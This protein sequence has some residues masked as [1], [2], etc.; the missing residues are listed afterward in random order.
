MIRAN[1]ITLTEEQKKSLRERFPQAWPMD[2]RES[3]VCICSTSYRDNAGHSRVSVGGRVGMLHRNIYAAVVGPIPEDSLVLHRCGNAW[4]IN[5]CHLYLGD[6][7]Q[8]SRDRREHGRGQNGERNMKAKLSL[9]DV[10]EIRRMEGRQIDI[11]K[12]FGVSQAAVSKIKLGL[13]WVE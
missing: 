5:P 4:C 6:A 10:E 9:L 8:N 2:A 13:T 7:K 3:G 11:A 12:K 1:A